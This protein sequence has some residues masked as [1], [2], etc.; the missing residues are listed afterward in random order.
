MPAERRE[1][2]C[3]GMIGVLLLTSVVSIPHAPGWSEP[4]VSISHP[5]GSGAYDKRLI[6]VDDFYVH[7]FWS[8][9]AQSTRIGHNIVLPD[10]TIIL[11]DTML[12]RDV[13]SAYLGAFQISPDSIAVFWREGTPTWY[14]I[15]SNDG[16]TLMPPT[17]LFN[18]PWGGTTFHKETRGDSDSLGLLHLIRPGYTGHYYDE[19][20]YSVVEPGG[21]TLWQD[22]VPGMLNSGLIVVDGER[23]HIKF[24]G[25]D[26]L[27]DYIQYDLEGNI[28]IPPMDVVENTPPVGGFSGYCGMCLDSSG[29][30]LMV[31]VVQRSGFPEQLRFYKID[32]ETGAKLVDAKVLFES[33][34]LSYIQYPSILPGPTPDCFYV[35]W[36]QEDTEGTPRLIMCTLIDPVGEFLEEPYV[37]YDYYSAGYPY[38]LQKLTA[39]TNDS[40]DVFLAWTAS[41]ITPPEPIILLGWFDHNYLGIEDDSPGSAEPQLVMNSSCN[42]FSSSVTITCE[43]EAL[44]GQLMVYDIT[45]RL[46]R[47][48]SDSEGSSFLWDGRDGTGADVPTGT[49]LIQGAVAGRVSSVRVVR[50]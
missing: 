1:D 44:P 16:G 7:Q 19:L 40:G 17:L 23:V 50:L 38:D 47:S 12:S 6:V 10:G 46:I 29:D 41:I 15:L 18:E 13:W 28:V 11:P 33:E 4:V 9:Y 26:Q 42:P 49:Y 22:T 27:A 37:A 48:L 31:I 39:T 20:L 8:S 5:V 25:M 24:D 2:G 43:G 45:G 32:A 34:L 35:V 21:S 36:L 3:P 14:T 30:V